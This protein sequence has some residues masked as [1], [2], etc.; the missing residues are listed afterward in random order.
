[1]FAF[2]KM[3]GEVQMWRN[4]HRYLYALCSTEIRLLLH[5]IAELA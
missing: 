3:K 2:S 4:V 5:V 1:M